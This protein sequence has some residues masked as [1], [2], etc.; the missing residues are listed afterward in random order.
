MG[1]QWK[2]ISQTYNCMHTV[3]ISRTTPYN[4]GGT[5][6][7]S[8]LWIKGSLWAG[9]APGLSWSI[10]QRLAMLGASLSMGSSRP[11]QTKEGPREGPGA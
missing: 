5:L 6:D 9:R 11:A 1:K 3:A 4:N 10:S 7:I 8:A 2:A